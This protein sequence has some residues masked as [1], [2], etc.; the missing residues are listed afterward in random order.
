MSDLTERRRLTDEVHYRATHDSLT[1]LANRADFET[2]LE[3]ALAS[4]RE[5]DAHH[6]LL[7]VDLDQ[8]Q[9]VNEACGH[10]AGDDF[11]REASSLIQSC[12]RSRDTLA[13]LGGDEF[14]IILEYCDIPDTREVAEK[15]RKRMDEFRFSFEGRSF[16]IGASIGLVTIDNSWEGRGQADEGRRHRLLCRQ[17][18]GPRPRRLL[19]R[20]GRLGGDAAVGNRLGASA[21]PGHHRESFHPFMPS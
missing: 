8:F 19:F 1:G 20:R 17:G 12:I 21:G 10:S 14:G 13:R 16:R 9:L 5:R 2:R 6:A 15:I 7:Y 18:G 11:L 4:A 3:R